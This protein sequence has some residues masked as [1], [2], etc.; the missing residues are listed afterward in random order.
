MHYLLLR[1]WQQ[2]FDSLQLEQRRI[3]IGLWNLQIKRNR[4]VLWRRNWSVS[5][6]QNIWIALK[7]ERKTVLCTNT[8]RGNTKMKKWNLVWKSPNGSGTPCLDKPMRLWESPAGGKTKF[9]TAKMSFITPQLPEY[10]WKEAKRDFQT[11]DPHQHPI[12]RSIV[13]FGLVRFWYRRIFK[14]NFW[15]QRLQNSLSSD[16]ESKFESTMLISSFNFP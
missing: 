9:W 6:G 2:K 4:D 11:E 13:K 3:S 7:E 5:S 15:W 1:N 12:N 8:S 10:Q 14:I 16:Q